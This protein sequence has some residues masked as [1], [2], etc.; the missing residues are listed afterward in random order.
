MGVPGEGGVENSGEEE[1]TARAERDVCIKCS[2]FHVTEW[3]EPVY[4]KQTDVYLH[5]KLQCLKV[6]WRRSKYSERR[7]YVEHIDGKRNNTK[8]ANLDVMDIFIERHLGRS[9]WAG[10]LGVAGVG[11]WDVCFF[12]LSHYF[13]LI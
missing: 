11:V 8:R 2:E 12:I 5:G 4:E 9:V 6:L 1:E 3:I 10:G 7:E 13:K